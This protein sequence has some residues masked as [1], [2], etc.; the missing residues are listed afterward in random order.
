MITST[1]VHPQV[2]G[3]AESS[4][5][6][7]INNLKK[8]LGAK[9]GKW[10]EE[11]PYV[12]CA[13]RTTPKNATGQTSFSLVFGAEAVIPTE[14]VYPTARTSILDPQRNDENLLHDLD[15]VEELKDQAR[16]RTAAYQQNM[17]GKYHE[18]KSSKD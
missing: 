5:K 9:K 11:I 12:L 16:F 3:Q 2:N 8:K 13:N 15:T 4:N 14:M 17:A 6:I 10:A 1:L 7:I 18:G